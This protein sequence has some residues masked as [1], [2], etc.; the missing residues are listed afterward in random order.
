MKY[1]LKQ[2]FLEKATLKLEVNKAIVIL[3]IIMI[4][5]IIAGAAYAQYVNHH[6][7]K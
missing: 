6:V 3:A 5:L 1:F 2:L 7:S 4:P